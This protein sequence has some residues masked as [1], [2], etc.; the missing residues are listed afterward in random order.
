MLLYSVSIANPLTDLLNEV[1]GTMSKALLGKKLG[2]SQVYGDGG[3]MVPVTII[4]AGPCT[5]LQK[6][7]VAKDSYAS[8][9]LGFDT[10]P[11]RVANGPERGHLKA[12]KSA[13]KRFVR[14][15]RMD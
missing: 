7:T 11:E 4:E 14:E 8:L 9:Q 2:M 3:Q 6:K 12:S 5:V 10:K 13:P 1:R 15:V